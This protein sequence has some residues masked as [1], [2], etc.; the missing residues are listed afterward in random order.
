MSIQTDITINRCLITHE[1]EETT[2][3]WHQTAQEWFI[4]RKQ[5]TTIIRPNIIDTTT[6]PDDRPRE[7]NWELLRGEISTAFSPTCMGPACLCFS[8]FLIWRHK[9]DWFFCRS[10]R[11][12]EMNDPFPPLTTIIAK[13]KNALDWFWVRLHQYNRTKRLFSVICLMLQKKQTKIKGNNN[14]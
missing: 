3:L 10:T 13:A 7:R 2:N 12:Y 1:K 4:A 6:T 14:Q 9:Y 11:M 8:S 5:Y